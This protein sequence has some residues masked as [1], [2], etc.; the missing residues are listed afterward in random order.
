MDSGARRHVMARE[1][2][3]G[4]HV[5]GSNSSR[6]GLGFVVGNGEHIPN[7][8]QCVVSFDADNGQGS[9]TPLACT[10]QVAD[11]TRPLVSVSQLCEQ[12][13]KVEFNDTHALVID[14][15]G[16]T[17]CKFQLPGHLHTNQMIL[18]AP[19]TF[20]RPSYPGCPRPQQRM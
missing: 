17:V 2:A 15:S 6:R 19:E 13:F 1:S 9:T 11:L 10:F 3:P 20:H 8:G 4:Y 18:K 5:H 7:E 14:S 16:E 12:G